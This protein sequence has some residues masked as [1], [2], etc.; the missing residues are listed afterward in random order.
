MVRVK[1]HFRRTKKG[2]KAVRAHRRRTKK[3]RP[4]KRRKDHPKPVWE[5]EDPRKEAEDAEN[6]KLSFLQNYGSQPEFLLVIGP[7]EELE[8]SEDTG[9]KADLSKLKDFGSKPTR[10]TRPDGKFKL[11]SNPDKPGSKKSKFYGCV[12]AMRSEQ[13][14]KKYGK[15]ASK[16]I[17][18]FIASK[19]K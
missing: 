8:G 4:W 14:G 5:P 13:Y 15:E 7:K 19:K 6:E 16:R 2:K 12:R 3:P 9:K 11:M 10:Y 1:R 17:C 18:G